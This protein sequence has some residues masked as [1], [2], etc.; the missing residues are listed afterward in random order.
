MA[1]T[2]C[3]WV[4]CV[5][6]KNSCAPKSIFSCTHPET[7]ASVVPVDAKKVFEQPKSWGTWEVRQ[8]TG[9]QVRERKPELG[10]VVPALNK[11]NCDH[12]LR[13]IPNPTCI[14]NYNICR[15]N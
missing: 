11:R 7:G 14:K 12:F 3:F 4:K 6:Y 5:P 10:A 2:R 1:T 9:E 13:C 8:F 15:Q